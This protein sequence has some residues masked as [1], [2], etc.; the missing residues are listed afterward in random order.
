MLKTFP[1]ISGDTNNEA[2]P[3]CFWL[4]LVDPSKDEVAL[5]RARFGIN[6]PARSALEEIEASSRLRLEGDILYMSAPLL[7]GTANEKWEVAPTG[8][9]LSPECCVTVRF[10]ELDAFATVIGEIGS[11]E[12]LE[13]VQVFVRLL[14]EVV[15]RAADHLEH[16]SGIVSDAFQAVF[17]DERQK[18]MLNEDTAMLSETIRKIGQASDRASRVR[19]MF[20]SIGRMAGFVMER[21]QPK[22]A[23]E[24]RGRLE[25]IRH[26]IASLDEFE[27][28]LAGRIQ[29]LQDAATSFLSI[30]QNDVVKLLTVVSVVGVPPVLVAGIY[31]MNFKYMPELGWHLG[32]P[33]ALVLCALSALL[34]LL[35]FKRRGWI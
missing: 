32:Y 27:A 17:F 29:L 4:D 9:I 3:N 31:G 21:R 20:L 5:V 7:A 10:A 19:Y 33:F 1:P 30:E 14:E 16:A 35:W 15:D 26:D 12:D 13:P 25:A 28:S 23:G 24:L 22:V 6:V 8:F 34:P 2:P 11:K 18:R